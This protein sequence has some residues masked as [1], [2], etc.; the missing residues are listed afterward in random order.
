VQAAAGAVSTI[1]SSLGNVSTAFLSQQTSAFVAASTNGGVWGRAVGGRVETK[2]DTAIN[3]ALVTP[4]FSPGSGNCTSSVK[5]SFWGFQAGRDLA[6]VVMNGWTLHW[7]STAGYLESRGGDIPSS[8]IQSE[9][10][11]PFIGSYLVATAGNFFSDVMVRR[12][13]F[14]GTIDQPALNL[15][16]QQ[17]G[18][19][20]WSVSAGAGYNFAV[21]D[22]WFV[23][24]SAGFFWSRTE[25]DSMTL[26]GAPPSQFGISGTL[27]INDID[28]KIGRATLRVGRNFSDN[29]MAWQ[30]FPSVSVYREFAGDVTASYATCPSCAAG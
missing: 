30:P 13:Y 9:F 14:N 7:G 1:S 19:R 11:V 26:A 17:F 16:N 21:Q 28:S 25:V 27:T 6:Q 15:H 29:V 10:Q 4:L 22:G 8:S 2:S 24:P 23:E 20:S 5:Q 18:A 3:G 12:E